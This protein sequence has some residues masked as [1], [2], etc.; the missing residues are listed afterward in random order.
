MGKERKRVPRDPGKGFFPEELCRLKGTKVQGNTVHN[1]S[2][3]ENCRVTA[4]FWVCPG[5]EQ[6]ASFEGFS[7]D[8]VCHFSVP[9]AS[10]WDKGQGKTTRSRNQES[11][12]MS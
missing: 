10:L 4:L 11:L 9:I 5:Y 2:F 8:Q 7:Q 3:P 6:A 12:T 1:R